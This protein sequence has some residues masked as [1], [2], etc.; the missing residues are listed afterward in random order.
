MNN[1]PQSCQDESGLL[2]VLN[3]EDEKNAKFNSR[4]DLYNCEKRRQCF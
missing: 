2:K 3:A 4:E 1:A